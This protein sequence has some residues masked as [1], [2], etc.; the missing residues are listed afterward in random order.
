MS[1]ISNW[2]NPKPHLQDESGLRPRAQ[3][4]MMCDEE[5]EFCGQYETDLLRANYFLNQLLS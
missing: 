5:N 4:A 3:R 2:F 1:W